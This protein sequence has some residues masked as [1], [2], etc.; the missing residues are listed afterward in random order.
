MF[1]DRQEELAFLNRLLTRQRPGPAQLVLLYGRRRVGKTALLHHWAEQSNLKYTY[2]VADKE[3]PNLMRRSLMAAVLNMP[4]DQAPAF[5]SWSVLWRWLAPQ[6]KEG[7]ERRILILDEISYA[8]AADPGILSALQQAW[9][10]HL[11]TSNIALVLCGSHVNTMEAI[12]QQQSPLFGRFTGQWR[13]QSLPFSALREFFPN[14]S[15]EE[16]V[17]SY[18]I[19]GGV[20]AYLNWLD[21]GLTLVNNIRQ[22]IL[23]PGSMFLAEPQLLLYDELQ[24]LPTYLAILRS[25]SEGNHTLGDISNDCLI[26]SSSLSAYL[27]RL[28]ELRMIE[29]RLPATISP[30]KQRVSKQGRYHLS[31]PFF[32][33]YF[34]FLLPH[35][36]SLASPDETLAHI[37]SE[38]RSFVG[39][40]FEQL[41]REW[42]VKQGQAGLLPFTPE[43]VGSHWSRKVQVDVAAVN[44]QSQEILLGECKWGTDK[45]NRQ[46]VRELIEHKGPLVRQEL[47]QG[48][49]NWTFHYALF[50]RSGFTEAATAEMTARQGLLIDLDIL[51]EGLSIN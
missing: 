4:E 39:L 31:D 1:V 27:A 15:A 50:S 28:Q 6:L 10:R 9:D 5:D 2:W 7:N 44:W 51:D 25:I 11:Q 49:E 18:A 29:R 47:P 42:V 38:L 24:E 43:A 46:V 16:R 33:F 48:G 3:P 34:R 36:R 13:L 40:A 20:P 41:A 12:L 37:R 32:R 23:M 45:V 22:V 21:P 19:V 26:G 35:L 30:A 14:W 17:A 8:S